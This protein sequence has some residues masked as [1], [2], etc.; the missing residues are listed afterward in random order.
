MIVR[1]GSTWKMALRLFRNQLNLNSKQIIQFSRYV[2]KDVSKDVQADVESVPVK[3]KEV[4]Y[5]DGPVKIVEKMTHTKQVMYLRFVFCIII[6]IVQNSNLI[7]LLNSV[8][9]LSLC[10]DVG[11]R[12]F[13]TDSIHKQR[14]TDQRTFC[15]RF[16]CRCSSSSMQRSCGQLRRWRWTIRPSTCIHKSRSTGCTQLCLLWN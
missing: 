3:H 14:E 7:K 8:L 1:L 13:P 11:W 10:L 4:V 6:I 9:F 15:D 12:R 2:S 5:E 16:D